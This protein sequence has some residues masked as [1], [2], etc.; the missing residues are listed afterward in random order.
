MFNRILSFFTAFLFIA[1]AAFAQKVIEKTPADQRVKWYND[2]L[3]LKEK[4][5]FKQVP[6]Q[7]VGPTNISGRM[8]DVEV[9]SPKGKNYTIYVAG[10]SGGIWKTENEGISWKPVFEHGLHDSF[11]SAFRYSTPV[12]P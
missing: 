5:I 3:D 1:S 7:F 10:A 2:Y 4:S 6:W 8:T 9:V 12:F 11:T